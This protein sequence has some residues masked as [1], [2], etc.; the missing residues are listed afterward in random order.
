MKDGVFSRKAILLHA[1]RLT[2]SI[3]F[4]L[5]NGMGAYHIRGHRFFLPNHFIPKGFF[6]R[7]VNIVQYNR[8]TE[9]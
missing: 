6:I 8:T 4:D 2:Q 7:R 1:I 3:V 9:L 5:T